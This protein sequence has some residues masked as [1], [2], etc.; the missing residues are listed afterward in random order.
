MLVLDLSAGGVKLQLDE[1]LPVR[2]TIRIRLNSEALSQDVYLEA[3]VCWCRHMGG[4]EW[5]MGCSFDSTIPELHLT[6]LAEAGCIEQSQG[7]RIDI[8]AE[9]KVKCETTGRLDRARMVDVSKGG[10]ALNAQTAFNQG[11][12]I[13]VQIVGRQSKVGIASRVRWCRRL[14][15]LGKFRIGCS[16]SDASGYRD[17]QTN[18]AKLVDHNRRQSPRYWIAILV[19]VVTTAALGTWMI[20]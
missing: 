2:S 8:E 7:N 17:C 13:I 1:S 12:R 9:V 18:L 15:D 20:Q 5:W 16:F 10:F 11:D 14:G 3:T 6:E 19:G 4:E